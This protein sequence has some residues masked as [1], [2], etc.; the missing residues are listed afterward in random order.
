MNI[1]LNAT[2]KHQCRRWQ[3]VTVEKGIVWLSRFH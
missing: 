1:E 3:Y 2:R